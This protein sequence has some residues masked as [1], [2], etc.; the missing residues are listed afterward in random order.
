MTHGLKRAGFHVKY[1]VDNDHCAA[2]TV[3][4]NHSRNEMM[5]FEEDGSQVLNKVQDEDPAY[6]S[7][8]DL[9]HVHASPPCQGFSKENRN[10]GAND[11]ANNELIY[12]FVYAVRIFKPKTAS[13]ENVN[14]ILAHHTEK[15]KNSTTL[16]HSYPGTR[17]TNGKKPK[18]HYLYRVVAD[19]L[20]LG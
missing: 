13:M 16:Q 5:V 18:S 3:R 20:G 14:V 19:L 12:Y 7:P 15:V 6:P 4:C 8:D 2:A 10:G 17:P 9:D 1:A 11:T